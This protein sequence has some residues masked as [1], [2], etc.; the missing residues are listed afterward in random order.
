MAKSCLICGKT[1]KLFRTR[2][3][4][5]A[6]KY[7]PTGKRRKYPNLQWFFVPKDISLKKYKPF[8]GKRILSCTKCIKRASKV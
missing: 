2:K 1:S 4:L 8:A 7:N 3:K 6:T 5:R